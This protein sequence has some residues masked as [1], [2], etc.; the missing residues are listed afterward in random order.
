MK[1]TLMLLLAAML[2]LTSVCALAE[3]NVKIPVKTPKE[4]VITHL[5]PYTFTGEDP[6]FGAIN[7]FLAKRGSRYLTQEGYV[8]IPAPL[9]V[10]IDIVDSNMVQ[11]F[12]N[13]WVFNYV[14]EGTVL[15]TISGG[16]N[17]GVINLMR[18]QDDTWVAIGMSTVAGGE[19]YQK[20][21]LTL[22]NDDKELTNR[23]LSIELTDGPTGPRAHFIRQYAEANNL[24]V[25]AYQD[26]GWEP[27]PLK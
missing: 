2:L 21:L 13:F 17:P 10:R 22:T 3:G 25:T 8:T 15:K 9:I 5:P 1:K 7:T 4:P 26:Y 16:E 14:L 11:V 23:I 18:T 20:Q 19:D 6:W 24:E 12:G 27:V